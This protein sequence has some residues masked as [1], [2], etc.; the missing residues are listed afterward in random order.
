[1]S[2]KEHLPRAVIVFDKFH[3]MKH[4]NAAVDEARRQEFFRQRGRLRAVMCGKRWLLL[5]RWTNLSR[6]RRGELNEAFALNR[7]LLKA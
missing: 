5:T 6:T 2:L 3:V 4:V 1:L 7:R